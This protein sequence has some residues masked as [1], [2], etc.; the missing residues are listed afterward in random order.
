LSWLEENQFYKILKRLYCFLFKLQ[1]NFSIHQLYLLR[2]GNPSFDGQSRHG[3]ITQQLV[4]EMAFVLSFQLLLYFYCSVLCSLN[5]SIRGVF[6]IFIFVILIQ[7]LTFNVHAKLPTVIIISGKVIQL[8]RNGS[9]WI[10][11]WINIIW[12]IRVR[13]PRVKLYS[14]I[15]VIRAISCCLLTWNFKLSNSL[16]EGN[17]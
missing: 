2:E 14:S 4:K 16:E 1:N 3:F 5:N 13:L 12:T 10:F 9:F 7:L 17:L 8:F 15:L 6:F 11:Y